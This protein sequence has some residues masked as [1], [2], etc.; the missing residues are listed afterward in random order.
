[1][2]VNR[3][4]LLLLLSLAVLPLTAVAGDPGPHLSRFGEGDGPSIV[5]EVHRLLDAAKSPSQSNAI[6]FDRAREGAFEIVGFRGKLRVTEGGDGGAFVFLNTA[7]YGVRGPAPYVRSWVEPNLRR[8]FAVGIDV[9]NPPNQ[10]PFSPWGNYQSLPQREVSLHWDGR[11]IVKRVAPVEF[12][13]KFADVAIT[14]HHVIGGADVTVSIA[15][16]AVYDRFFVA[17]LTPYES[18]LAIGAGTRPDAT[19]AFDV[20]DIAFDAT[21][22]ATRRRPPVRVEVFHHVMTDNATTSYDAEVSLP[23]ADWAFGRVLLSLDI[24]DGGKMWDEWDRN[25]RIAILTEEGDELVIVPFI[26]SYRT[27]CHWIVDVTHFRPILAGEV[28][29]RIAAGTNFY[30]NRGYLMSVALDFHH[31]TP[32]L[33]PHAVVPLWNGIAKYRSAENHFRDFFAARTVVIPETT[34]AARLFVT[35]TGHSQ[36]GEFTPS[37]RTVLF[38]P[39]KDGPA[40]TVKRFENVL[41][42]TDCYLNPNRPQFGTWKFSRAG[43]A[44]GD[45]V[46]P[47]W[48]DITP[49]LVPGKEAELRYEPE[50]YDFSGAARAPTEKQ[51]NA[52]SHVVR[53]YLILYREPTALLPA[54]IV[55]ITN[56]AADS[57]AGKAGLK[58]GDYLVSYDGQRVDSVDDLRK[59]LEAAVAAKKEKVTVVIRRGSKRLEVEMQSGRMG[60]NLS[61]Q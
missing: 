59:A 53:S 9:H 7:E 18:R 34:K 30:K 4:A 54:P 5:D 48:I 23:P 19:A 41:W 44:P 42:K 17:G 16:T 10:E 58:R 50:P 13:G 56:V 39:E 3:P 21:E 20:R 35:T 60:V 6:A 22:P 25:G 24:H 36:V 8:T 31:G 57:S 29:F 27:P 45:V 33:E 55:R 1:M 37:K 15:G 32:A 61:V 46:R 52:A 47:W 49:H 43:W 14:V 28:R 38:T 12:R 11:E 40:D 51:I 26:T 2:I